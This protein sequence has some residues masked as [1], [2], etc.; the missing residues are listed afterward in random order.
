MHCVF[1]CAHVRWIMLEFVLLLLTPSHQR[2]RGSAAGQR[3]CTASTRC[4]SRSPRARGSADVP[5]RCTASTRCRS[6]SP[7]ARG[8]A[9]VPHRC[10][11]STRRRSPSHQ[12]ALGR[13]RGSSQIVIII[14]CLVF[15]PSILFIHTHLRKCK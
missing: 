3:R 1:M 4:R 10:T 11:A 7:R 6:R 2:A 8:S 5:H 15:L 13:R 9:D 12:R 14:N